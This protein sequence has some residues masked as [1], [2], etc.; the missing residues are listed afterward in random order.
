MSLL[1]GRGQAA[2]IGAQM[3]A[4]EIWKLPKESKKKILKLIK[5]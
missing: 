1:A 5:I 3:R 2:L 4:E